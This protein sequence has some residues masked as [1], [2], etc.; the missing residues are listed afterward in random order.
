MSRISIS[1]KTTTNKQAEKVIKDLKDGFV[2]VG[3][4]KEEKYKNGLYVAENAYM[5]EN[6]FTITHKNGKRTYVPKRPFL[7]ITINKNSNKWQTLW[8]GLYK[9]V[10]DGKTKLA[11]ALGK[12]GVRIKDDIQAT[13][14]SNVKP[15]NAPSTQARKRSKHRPLITLMDT[16]KMYSSINYESVVGKNK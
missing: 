6:G 3:W 1:L 16:K 5:Q 15:D 7:S 11:T 12:L 4:I 14:R 13:I 2:K 8:K 10:L 9:S